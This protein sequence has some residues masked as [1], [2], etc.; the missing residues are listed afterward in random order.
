[1]FY[2][3]ASVACIDFSIKMS[4]NRRNITHRHF[5]ASV[6]QHHILIRYATE[7]AAAETATAATEAATA[8]ATTEAEM[9]AAAAQQQ[10]LSL[11]CLFI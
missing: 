6:V 2:P 3:T 7:I 1:M 9:E 4:S 5:C 8:A 10:H 11:L